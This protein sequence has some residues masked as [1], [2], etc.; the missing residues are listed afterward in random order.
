MFC[1]LTCYISGV[2]RKVLSF[3][4]VLLMSSFR[5]VT[6]VVLLVPLLK[7]VSHSFSC[8]TVIWKS[9]NVSKQLQSPFCDCNWK[10]FCSCDLIQ[11]LIRYFVATG[12]QQLFSTGFC[13][14]SVFSDHLLTHPMFHSCTTIHFSPMSHTAWFWLLVSFSISFSRWYHSLQVLWS[15]VLFF[16]WCLPDRQAL[17]LIFVSFCLTYSKRVSF[18][19]NCRSSSS[20][21]KSEKLE[22][23]SSVSRFITSLHSLSSSFDPLSLPI[24][25]QQVF[26]CQ[27]FFCL[28]I[29]YVLSFFFTKCMK[30]FIVGGYCFLRQHGGCSRMFISNFKLAL[31]Y[32]VPCTKGQGSIQ[33][34]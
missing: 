4:L 19:L 11:L 29:S 33:F 24:I 20:V 16:S 22:Y 3:S 21:Q 23:P 25:Y 30:F 1:R 31:I 28:L 15:P 27:Y 14:N 18:P 34:N 8:R 13:E 12:S 17:I 2:T 26:A 5:V 9:Q 10:W 6:M 7:I 32:T